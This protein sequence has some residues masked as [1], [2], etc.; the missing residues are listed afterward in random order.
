MPK[1]HVIIFCWNFRWE[2]KST[3]GPVPQQCERL[4]TK[5]VSENEISDEALK[6]DCSAVSMLIHLND[7]GMYSDF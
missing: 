1:G 5:T 2:L 3:L 6:L 7:I 4:I